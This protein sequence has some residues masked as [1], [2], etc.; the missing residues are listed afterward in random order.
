MA[1][2]AHTLQIALGVIS[3]TKSN[4]GMAPP[5]KKK[6]LLKFLFIYGKMFLSKN[7]LL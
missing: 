6:I 1:D 5:P 3:D 4:L 2:M 7:I